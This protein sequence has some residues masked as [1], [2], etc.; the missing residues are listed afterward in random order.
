MRTYIIYCQLLLSTLCCNILHI[1]TQAGH[2]CLS[3]RGGFDLIKALKGP[4]LGPLQKGAARGVLRT[5]CQMAVG[6]LQWDQ[7][8]KEHTPL[9]QQ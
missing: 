8:G 2:L 6:K 9:Q 3:D 7:M 4:S 5:G 1:V